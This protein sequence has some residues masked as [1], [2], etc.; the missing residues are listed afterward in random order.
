M[1]AWELHVITQNTLTLEKFITKLQSL[2]RDI[3]Y[4]PTEHNEFICDFLGFWTV[5]E[6]SALKKGTP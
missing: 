6:K 3:G 5:S 4:P 2:V 1:V